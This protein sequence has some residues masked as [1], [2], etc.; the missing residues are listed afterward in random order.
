MAL[1]SV[2]K[3]E[4]QKTLAESTA[5]S[6]DPMWF[7]AAQF[8]PI[9]SE[10]DLSLSPIMTLL[11]RDEFIK[12][13]FGITDKVA[14]YYYKLSEGGCVPD[15]TVET[16][17][18]SGTSFSDTL[19]VVPAWENSLTITEPTSGLALTDVRSDPWDGSGILIDSGGTQRGTVNYY[20]GAV[21]FTWTTTLG[22]TVTINY[23]YRN[24]KKMPDATALDVPTLDPDGIRFSYKKNFTVGTTTVS[25]T[26]SEGNDDGNGNTPVYFEGGIFSE[27]DVMVAHFILDKVA[28]GQIITRSFSLGF[29]R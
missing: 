19:G 7:T 27:N 29:V 3:I 9:S 25:L 26:A 14:V 24:T 11:G 5:S 2:D 21:S 13:L 16:F 12:Q 28:G 8:G 1:Y 10:N 4:A 23:S 22:S 17:S 6:T 20:T 18:A 15:A